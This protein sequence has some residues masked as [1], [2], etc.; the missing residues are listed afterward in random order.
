MIPQLSL[1]YINN[2]KQ[3][4]YFVKE[5][6]AICSVEI[7]A[8]ENQKQKNQATRSYEQIC[9]LAISNW[10]AVEESQNFANFSNNPPVVHN[11][12]AS[13]ANNDWSLDFLVA[14]IHTTNKATRN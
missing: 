6:Y 10:F 8:R 7:I 5:N 14:R 4:I 1:T 9:R 11:L 13:S 3:N 12:V 2:K